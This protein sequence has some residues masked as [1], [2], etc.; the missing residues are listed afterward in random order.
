MPT[1]HVRTL[2]SLRIKSLNGNLFPTYVCDGELVPLQALEPFNGQVV[3]AEYD[4][5][6]GSWKIRIF[7]LLVAVKNPTKSFN[8][9]WD[10]VPV[11]FVLGGV[12]ICPPKD[13]FEVV[14]DSG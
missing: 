8:D 5:Q 11:I 9:F 2:G 12:C 6:W 13:S 7:D 4:R 1:I 10:K 14:D 3:P